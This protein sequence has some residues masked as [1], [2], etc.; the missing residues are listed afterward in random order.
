[1]QTIKYRNKRKAVSPIIATLILIVIT[2]AA[3]VIIYYFVSGYLSSTTSSAT[4]QET[5]IITNVIYYKNSTN[6][7]F[8]NV[9]VYNSGSTSINIT[10]AKVLNPTGSVVAHGTVIKN[11]LVLP[12]QTVVINIQLNNTLIKGTVYTLVTTTVQGTQQ[13]FTFK[14]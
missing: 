11:G 14:A 12:G 7:P 5:Y 2:V 9:T 6:A 13:T 10:S 3:G 8:I 1:M 4:N